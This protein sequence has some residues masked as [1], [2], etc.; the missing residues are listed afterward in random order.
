MKRPAGAALL[1]WAQTPQ[2]E[3]VIEGTMGGL[4]AGLP[5]FFVQDQDPG[6][7]A[8]M[9]AGA[10]AGGIGVGMAGRR[11]GA[12][13]GKHINPSALADQNGAI[14][15]IAR[16]A[17]SES[18]MEGLEQQGRVMRGQVA[19]YLLEKQAVEMIQ[20]GKVS[21]E[22]MDELRGM[23]QFA[24]GVD[25][26]ENAT[27]EQR[28]AMLKKAGY[29]AEKLERLSKLEKELTT[30]AA[31]QMDKH[32][33]DIAALMEKENVDVPM[34]SPEMIRGMSQEPEVVTGE[35]VGRAIGRFLGDEIGVLGG[36]GLG[37]FAAGQ[38]G[39][40]SPKDKEIA[41]LKAQLGQ[42]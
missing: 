5:M 15:A 27:P 3:E 42:A 26:L 11:I 18:L 22:L 4:L 29:T 31:G 38:L 32:L 25:A 30:G 39:M 36:V 37:A 14:A 1:E 2:G 8:L 17:G 35:H 24:A 12:A 13:L 33:A 9:T 23:R 40:Q 7:A 28:A 6:S 21:P 16:T 41:R 19:D 10:I 20:S 34:V